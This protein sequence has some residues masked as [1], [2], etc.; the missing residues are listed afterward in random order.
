MALSG[1]EIELFRRQLA[2]RRAV[3]RKV[4]DEEIIHHER[5]N[6][7]DI[8]GRVR[9]TGDDSL[10]RSIADLNI[11]TLDRELQE[12]R[13]IDAAVARMD[14]GDYGTCMDCGEPIQLAR[15]SA[16]PTARRCLICQRRHEAS[17]AGNAHPS[18]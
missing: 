18:M 11:R 1:K 5:E 2:E 7:E 3:L 12:M 9:D 6:Y 17:H 16:Y 10:A 4:V 13:D 14:S 15:L 8:L